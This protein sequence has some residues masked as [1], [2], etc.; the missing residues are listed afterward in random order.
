MGAAM[1]AAMGA[2]GDHRTYKALGGGTE[3]E[4]PPFIRRVVKPQYAILI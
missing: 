3:Q 4:D 1:G 2:R